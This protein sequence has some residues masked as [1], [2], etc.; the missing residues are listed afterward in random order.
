MTTK[1]PASPEQMRS[2]AQVSALFN[3]RNIAIIGASDR[4][5]GYA[6]R[7]FRNLKRYGFTG[8]I[9]PV[10]PGRT[11]VWDMACYPDLRSL[12]Q[13]PDQ[14]LILVPAAKV[15][16]ALDDAAQCGARSATIFSSGFE[17]TQTEEGRIL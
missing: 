14:V 4:P 17:E 12:P 3:P 5:Q 13:P 11:E 6:F 7:V 15:C 2:V 10:N 8:P 16:Q 9:Y 1:L